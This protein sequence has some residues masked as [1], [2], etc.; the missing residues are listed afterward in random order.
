MEVLAAK[1]MH[2]VLSIIDEWRR[3]FH[4]N[5]RHDIIFQ[6]RELLANVRF[7]N[8]SLHNIRNHTKGIELVP[9]T[10][11][12]PDEVW[13]HWKN[14]EDQKV[15]NRSYIK[16]GKDVAFIVNTQDGLIMDAFVVS[17]KAADKYRN[18]CILK[19]A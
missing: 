14:V 13:S 4:V 19:R 6:N 7:N 12:H 17:K 16:Y 3:H 5:S 9:E 2:D 11:M 8:N 10:V 15:V 18:G 1:R